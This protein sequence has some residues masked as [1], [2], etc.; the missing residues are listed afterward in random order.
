MLSAVISMTLFPY[1]A[2]NL[3]SMFVPAIQNAKGRD[4]LTFKIVQVS[5]TALWAS[6]PI[7]WALS[8]LGVVSHPFDEIL[9]C[10]FNFLGKVRVGFFCELHNSN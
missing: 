6:L 3:W 7:L 5:T 1:V 8:H 10:I 4:S 9:V 2:Y